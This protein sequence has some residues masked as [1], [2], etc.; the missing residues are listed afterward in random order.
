MNCRGGLGELGH[1]RYHSNLK[2][3]D[4]VLPSNESTMHYLLFNVTS[5]SSPCL[6]TIL[7]QEIEYIEK[8]VSNWLEGKRFV[9]MSIVHSRMLFCVIMFGLCLKILSF[10]WFFLVF[11]FSMFKNRFAI[12]LKFP[13]YQLAILTQCS[14][15]SQAACYILFL[16]FRVV[17]L[18]LYRIFWITIRINVKFW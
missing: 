16:K 8:C 18:D 9:S 2:H 13:C 6:V 11:L 17:P 14:S 5:L 12:F 7:C 1:P 10:V 3:N 15:N 4:Q